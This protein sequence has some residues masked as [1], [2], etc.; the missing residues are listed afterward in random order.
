VATR[1]GA[2]EVTIHIRTAEEYIPVTKDEIFEAKREGVRIKGLRTPIGVALDAQGRLCG[3][4]F[5]QNRL[6]AWRPDG[7][8]QAIPIE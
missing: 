8:R 6:G 5:V 4:E 2:K 7:R 3:V 1:L